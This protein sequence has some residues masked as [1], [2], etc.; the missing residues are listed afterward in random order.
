MLEKRGQRYLLPVDD[1]YDLGVILSIY[2]DVLAVKIIMPQIR[3]LD[4]LIKR[5]QVFD[6]SEVAS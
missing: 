4:R 6:D 1:A 2:E 3:R 5:N